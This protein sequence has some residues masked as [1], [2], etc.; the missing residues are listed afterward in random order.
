MITSPLDN[1]K[2]IKELKIEKKKNTLIQL[3]KR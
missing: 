1:N 2:N 3:Y